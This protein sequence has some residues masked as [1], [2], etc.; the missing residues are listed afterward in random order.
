LGELVGNIHHKFQ[1]IF[2]PLEPDGAGYDKV[3]PV[4]GVFEFYVLALLVIGLPRD[5]IAAAM[6]FSPD[7]KT[8]FVG[9]GARTV[10]IALANIM[11]VLLDQTNNIK[12]LLE[13]T[14]L[15]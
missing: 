8:R 11:T 13:D 12:H 6:G 7:G 14:F 3:V 4:M 10:V 2:F 9:D 5:T 1:G 15:V